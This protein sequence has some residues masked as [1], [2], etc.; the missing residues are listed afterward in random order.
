MIKVLCPKVIKVMPLGNKK[1]N[2]IKLA[3]HK[4][5]TNHRKNTEQ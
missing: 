5:S 4:S 1:F 2:M 3:K